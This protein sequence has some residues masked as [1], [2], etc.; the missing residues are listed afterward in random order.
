M[1]ADIQPG[2][3]GIVLNFVENMAARISLGEK[4]V[5]LVT[6]PAFFVIGD[7]IIVGNIL[8]GYG[9]SFGKWVPRIHNQNH[10]F[11]VDQLRLKL[12][13][14]GPGAKTDIEAVILQLRQKLHGWFDTEIQADFLILRI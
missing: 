1:P 6:D 7:K 12:R 13:I 14:A 10:A 5:D 4:A 9:L 8:H 3:D 2:G 11:A